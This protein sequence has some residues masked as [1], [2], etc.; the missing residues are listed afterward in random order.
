[1]KH[2][3]VTS[4]QMNRIA[5]ASIALS[6]VL[7]LLLHPDTALAQ[8]DPFATAKDKACQAQAGLRQLAGALG[9]VGMV[10]CLMLG[11]FNKLN[12]KWLSTGIGVC[13]TINLVPSIISFVA[14]SPGC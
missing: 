11:F 4:K 5:W 13:F 2:K 12:W 9:A 8:A 7:L 14:G 3:P 10:A 6:L 1:M